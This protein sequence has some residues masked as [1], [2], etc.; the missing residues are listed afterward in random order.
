MHWS[1]IPNGTLR[2]LTIVLALVLVCAPLAQQP[3]AHDCCPTHSGNCQKSIDLSSQ[4]GCA[5]AVPAFAPSVARNVDAM[6]NLAQSI[7]PLPQNVN[8]E[9]AGSFSTRHH[10]LAPLAPIPPLRI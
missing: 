8:G 6:S 7:A 4:L 5:R 1:S 10:A 3:C 9:R 2:F